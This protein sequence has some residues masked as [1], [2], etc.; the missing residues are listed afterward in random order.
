MTTN[1]WRRYRADRHGKCFKCGETI[2]PGSNI[3][4]NAESKRRVHAQCHGKP[5][6]PAAKPALPQALSTH[7]ETRDSQEFT[8]HVLPN[9]PKRPRQKTKPRRKGRHS[10][11]QRHNKFGGR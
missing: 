6:K 8:V 3:F 7:T 2:W 4:W 10:A 9:T 1:H 11:K 5:T